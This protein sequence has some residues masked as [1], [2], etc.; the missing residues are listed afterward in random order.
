[1][2]W[3]LIY[4]IAGA[5]YFYQL[6]ETQQVINAALD[7]TSKWWNPMEWWR[8]FANPGEFDYT[9][10]SPELRFEVQPREVITAS[11]F[12][13]Y[14]IGYCAY[15]Q[16]GP[17]GKGLALL[18]GASALGHLWGAS[19]WYAH[20]IQRD[21]S[22]K[23]KRWAHDDFGSM[24]YLARGAY[25]VNRELFSGLGAQ[26]DRIVL[27]AAVWNLDIFRKLNYFDYSEDSVRYR[28]FLPPRSWRSFY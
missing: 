18:G 12:T 27:G 28:D 10:F 17:Y 25:D 11:E 19:D 23:Y 13:N 5:G 3:G 9:N 21:P 15:Y 26:F 22:A 4:K 6:S 8:A 14:L 1:M 2:S 7:A 16:G 24:Y 20:H